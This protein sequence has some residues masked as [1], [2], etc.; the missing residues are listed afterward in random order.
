MLSDMS[1]NLKPLKNQ[2]L[3]SYPLY[4]IVNRISC[5]VVHCGIL[6]V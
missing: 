2:W 5:P 1:S 4:I 6:K 3:G